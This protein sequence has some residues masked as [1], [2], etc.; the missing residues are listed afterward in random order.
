MGDG[1]FDAWLGET[2][3]NVQGAPVY[4]VDGEQLKRA[5]GALVTRLFAAAAFERDAPHLRAGLHDLLSLIALDTTA[6]RDAYLGAHRIVRVAN[7]RVVRL[8]RGKRRDEAERAMRAEL[9]RSVESALV[10]AREVIELAQL[11]L[12]AQGDAAAQIKSHLRDQRDA[13]GRDLDRALKEL[14]VAGGG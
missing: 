4:S 10:A 6:Y 7:F 9:A 13:V 2:A 11:V 12:D 14:A 8:M 1:R 3:A 5:I